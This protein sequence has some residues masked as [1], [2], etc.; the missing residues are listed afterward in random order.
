M[1]RQLG[2]SEEV[3]WCPPALLLRKG[4]TLILTSWS[5]C[6]GRETAADLGLL[7]HTLLLWAL[8]HLLRFHGVTSGVFHSF[9]PQLCG[10][11]LES[12]PR[13]LAKCMSS[14]SPC[15]TQV[16]ANTYSVQCLHPHR[17]SP[18]CMPLTASGRLMPVI[19]ALVQASFLSCMT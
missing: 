16:N 2:N 3:S 14:Y 4:L 19:S 9:L 7:S 8:V 17:A 15:I 13:T 1:W 5:G 6:R 12:V 18:H 10:V 11:S